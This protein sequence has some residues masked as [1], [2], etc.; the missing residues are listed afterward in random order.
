M[1][2]KKIFEFQP[3]SDAAL[4]NNALMWVVGDTTGLLFK[5]SIQQLKT[6]ISTIK[7]T[8]TLQQT[9]DAGATL[10]KDNAVTLAA[11]NLDFTGGTVRALNSTFTM[12]NTAS[13]SAV[14]I[15]KPVDTSWVKIIN[16]DQPNDQIL[17]RN[18]NN[19]GS[20]GGIT[21]GQ[22]GASGGNNYG[23]LRIFSN[24]SNYDWGGGTG[25]VNQS[26]ITF[27]TAGTCRGLFDQSGQFS[28]GAGAS[29]ILNS[30]ATSAVV[31][32]ASTSRG[33]YLP[34][35]TKA[36]R[37]AIVNPQAGLIVYQTDNTAGLRVFNGTDWMKFTETADA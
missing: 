16:I 5:P 21:R 29:G 6:F 35:M 15:V 2:G 14:S 10:T 1:A 22:G 3:I 11:H 9:L 19:D 7:P 25:V 37:N 34:R 24:S 32:I 27:Y 4:N 18:G 28:V 26:F 31:N 13:T 36:Q 17:F 8:E 33:V 23:E 30:T 20:G 12:F